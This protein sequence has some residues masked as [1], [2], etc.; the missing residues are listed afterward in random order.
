MSFRDSLLDNSAADLEYHPPRGASYL[1]LAAAPFCR[2][3]LP[4]ADIRFPAPSVFFAFGGITLLSKGL[5]LCRKSSGGL[6]LTETALNNLSS[7]KDLPSIPNLAAQVVQ[8]F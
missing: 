1:V 3:F 7:R 5:F 6:G 4:P 8:D 2:F